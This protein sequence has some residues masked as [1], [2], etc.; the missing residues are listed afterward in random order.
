MGGCARGIHMGI[1][2]FHLRVRSTQSMLSND[3]ELFAGYGHLAS[4]SY[5]ATLL[6]VGAST[7]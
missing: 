6:T 1:A 2:G 7:Q 3:M 5:V 4:A